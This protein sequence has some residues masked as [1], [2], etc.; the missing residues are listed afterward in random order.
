MLTQLDYHRL[1]VFYYIYSSM[2]I[3]GAAKNLNITRSAVSQ[4]LKKLEK[5]VQTT[6]FTRM[7]KSLVPT[8]E[9]DHLFEVLEPFCKKLEATT[10][11]FQ[12][13]KIDP[14]GLI[15]LGAPIEFG[16]NY[17][18]KIIADF[19]KTFP[20]VS[21][22][23]TLG[24]PEKLITMVKQGELDF[25]VVDLFITH[26]KYLDHLGMYSIESLV[27]EEIVLIC[28]KEYCE[29]RVK[30]DFS[31]KNL[32]Q[33]EY[34]AYHKTSLV[35]GNWFKHHFG[36]T[37]VKLNIA[38][39]VNSVQA[40]IAAIQNDMGLGVVPSH[41]VYDEILTGS[42]VQITTSTPNIINQM[43]LVQLQ[44]KVPNLAEKRFK[45]F[46]KKG[47]REDDI[48]KMFCKMSNY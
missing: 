13:G 15:R 37:S 10:R 34:I 41:V 27:D 25:G 21:F 42:I 16:N 9:A 36:K 35:L 31:L 40:V 33:Q 26:S 7:H 5:E 29:R 46:L 48:L 4:N 1:K 30:E 19:R 12:Q 45:E 8:L 3:I 24:D 43:S 44:D 23:L 38:L 39:T 6:L 18:Q 20:Q 28:S 2:S 32:I 22:T 11:S 14:R 47:V 17:L